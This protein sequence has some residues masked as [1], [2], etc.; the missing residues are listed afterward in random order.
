MLAKSC[1]NNSRSANVGKTCTAEL[2]ATTG[3]SL[4]V[5]TG[6]FVVVEAGT[7]GGVGAARGVFG[8]VVVTVP[9]GRFVVV[10]AVEAGTTGVVGAAGAGAAGGV[11]G[12]VVVTTGRF[13]VVDTGA[14]KGVLRSIVVILTVHR[15]VTF[16]T[17]PPKGSSVTKSDDELESWG[18]VNAHVSYDKDVSAEQLAR[19]RCVMSSGLSSRKYRSTS[20]P[21]WSS[22]SDEEG[23]DVEFATHS[24]CA[25]G[26]T[27]SSN[28]LSFRA[29]NDMGP[30]ITPFAIGS[31]DLAAM[32]HR[33]DRFS[34]AVDAAS[35]TAYSLGTGK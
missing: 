7:T 20:P 14:A 30:I 21:A 17:A 29:S 1:S 12:S 26:A 18:T 19:D 35:T 28:T 33:T 22:S 6:R 10:D 13:V 24:T 8:S 23:E 11:F 2:A 5:T 31:M 34:M 15:S 25:D 32:V 9:T 3:A 27:W 16:S 4:A